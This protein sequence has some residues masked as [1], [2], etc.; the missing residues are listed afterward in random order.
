MA[1]NL[2]LAALRQEITHTRNFWLINHQLEIRRQRLNDTR[3]YFPIPSLSLCLQYRR[4]GRRSTSIPQTQP[5]CAALIPLTSSRTHWRRPE[6]MFADLGVAN[7]GTTPPRTTSVSSRLPVE[8]SDSYTSRSEEPRPNVVIVALNSLAYVS[9][10]R[11]EEAFRAQ[12][13]FGR[14]SRESK[15]RHVILTVIRATGSGSPTQRICHHVETQEDRSACLWRLPMQ[16]LRPGPDCASVLDRG[17]ED[18]QEGAEG[19]SGEEDWK[20]VNEPKNLRWRTRCRW[21]RKEWVSLLTIMGAW[22]C[23]STGPVPRILLGRRQSSMKSFAA[24]NVL[25][26]GS[27]FRRVHTPSPRDLIEGGRRIETVLTHV[28]T[29]DLIRKPSNKHSSVAFYWVRRCPC[30]KALVAPPQCSTI[31]RQTQ[32]YKKTPSSDHPS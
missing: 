20:E 10:P 31:R 28:T 22:G 15:E 7:L 14:S 8:S 12:L 18:R 2:K 17:A 29:S 19:D 32:E 23:F 5:V 24:R 27:P 30:Q 25:H 4:N 1:F 6:N 11:L 26:Q 21:E 16:Q 13:Q 9:H 3:F